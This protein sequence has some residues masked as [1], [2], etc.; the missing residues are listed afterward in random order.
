MSSGH[1]R[2]K[3]NPVSTRPDQDLHRVIRIYWMQSPSSKDSTDHVF[4]LLNHYHSTGKFRRQQIE[5]FFLFFPQKTRFD[6]SCKLSS[7]ETICMNC[8]NLFSGKN[9]KNFSICHLLKI[10]PRVLSTNQSIYPVNKHGPWYI[11]WMHLRVVMS[12]GL[13]RTAL[14]LF[15]KLIF[16]TLHAGKNF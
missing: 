1:A 6:T 8:Q 3:F 4:K 11:A 14:L 9:K 16:N 13:I 7:M 5:F 12:A 10:F 15:W 2:T